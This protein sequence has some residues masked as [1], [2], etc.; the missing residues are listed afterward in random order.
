MAQGLTAVTEVVGMLSYNSF[1]FL[2]KNA[3]QR[4][5][6]PRDIVPTDSV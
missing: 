4:S 5:K 2:Q 1:V 3:R 6:R